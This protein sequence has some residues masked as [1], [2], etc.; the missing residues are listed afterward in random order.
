MDGEEAVKC[1]LLDMTLQLHTATHRSC[2]YLYAIKP[3]KTAAEWRRDH[4]AL[5]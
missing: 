3:V 4:N 5:P 2:A 1:A